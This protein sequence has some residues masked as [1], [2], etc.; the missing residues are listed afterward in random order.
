MD[1]F[2]AYTATV[3]EQLESL[4]QLVICWLPPNVTSKYQPLDQGI[5]KA[6]KAHYRRQW[7]Q[8]MLDEFEASKQPLKTT[9]VLKAIRWTIQ[10]WQAVSPLTIHHC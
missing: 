8:Y 10:A 2:S 1:N 3:T 9:N 7:L 4:Q 5:I 6:F